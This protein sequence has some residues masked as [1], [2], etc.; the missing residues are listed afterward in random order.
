MSTILPNQSATGGAAQFIAVPTF[1]SEQIVEAGMVA[2]FGPWSPPMLMAIKGRTCGSPSEKRLFI[3][4][5]TPYPLLNQTAQ[6]NK[7]KLEHLHLERY[8]TDYYMGTR[9]MPFGTFTDGNDPPDFVV[10]DKNGRLGVDCT[11]FTA[12]ERRGAYALFEGLRQAILDSDRSRLEHLRGLFL[13]LWFGDPSHA[14]KL[15]PKKADAAAVGSL[16]GRLVQYRHDP[17]KGIV[18][19]SEGMPEQAPDLGI[20]N[21]P[22]GSFYGTPIQK[23]WPLSLFFCSM[24]FELGL[25]Y[26]TTHSPSSVM[27]EIERLVTKH[28]KPEVDHLLI[29][30]GGPNRWGLVYPCEEALFD[31]LLG[32]GS[33]PALTTD[34]IKNVTLHS[35]E[36][37]RIVQLLPEGKVINPGSF[38]SVVPAHHVLAPRT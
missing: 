10:T 29:T 17:S 22:E 16:L 38:R 25:D 34:H 5:E 13:F 21:A 36:T 3:G 8:L 27:G 28:D 9:K 32:T 37:G 31:L 7:H 15:P 20:E 33:L 2:R 23:A 4:Y 12:Q 26:S 24:G 18:P 1:I 35:W 30:V 11:Q 19:C 6:M 14:P